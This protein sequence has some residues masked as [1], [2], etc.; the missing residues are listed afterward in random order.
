[1]ARNDS[2][3]NSASCSNQP[4]D[5]HTLHFHASPISC[6]SPVPWMRTLHLHSFT[7]EWTELTE[8]LNQSIAFTKFDFV[9]NLHFEVDLDQFKPDTFLHIYTRK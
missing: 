3:S 6:A 7:T 1:M 4:K 2:T 5:N 9:V 8:E